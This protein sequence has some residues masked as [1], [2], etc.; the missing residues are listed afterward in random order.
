MS[1]WIFLW[2]S[3]AWLLEVSAAGMSALS[4]LLV[5]G[6]VDGWGQGIMKLVLVLTAKVEISLSSWKQKRFF[7]IQA[8]H[9]L[10]REVISNSVN[11]T[12]PYPLVI[13]NLFLTKGIVYDKTS[14]SLI[15]YE[16]KIADFCT[17]LPLSFLLFSINPFSKL[18]LCLIYF[19]AKMWTK[20]SNS[21]MN[22]KF[23]SKFQRLNFQLLKT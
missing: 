2:Y 20:S 22:F 19:D 13:L 18:D 7:Q 5:A 21:Q 11:L 8:L 10:L 15:L 4:L 9:N 14:L 16:I 6:N 17:L 12:L 3:T 23:H 1:T